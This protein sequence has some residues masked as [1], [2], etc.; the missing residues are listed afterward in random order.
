MRI[1]TAFFSFVWLSVEDAQPM[2]TELT[3]YAPIGKMKQARYRPAVFNVLAAITNPTIATRRPIVMCHV[4]S[5]IRPELQPVKIP[6]T[7]ARMNGGQVRTRVIVRLKPRVRTTL[8]KPLA[9]TSPVYVRYSRRKERVEGAGAQMEVLHEAEQ[10]C[11]RI[12]TRLSQSL[13]GAHRLARI[14][15]AI[16][17]HARMCQLTL[18]WR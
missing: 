12:S 9:R 15:H 7:P 4:R 11:A 6:A 1:R 3:E 16:T 14:A 2:M 13:H 8:H 17:F 18:F 10:P 5:C